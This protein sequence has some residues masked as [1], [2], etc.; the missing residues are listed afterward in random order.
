MVGAGTVVTKDVPPFAIVVGNPA[1]IIGY[2]QANKDHVTASSAVSRPA[3]KPVQDL[4]IGGAALYALPMVSDL[5]GN[6]SF[7]E[8]EQSLPFIPKRYFL[9]FDVPSKDVRGEHAHRECHQ[10]LVCVKGSCSVVV[11]DGQNRAEVLLNSPNLG[12]HV[13]PWVWATEYKYSQDAVL[14]VLAS[15]VYKAEDYIR[16]Y[17]VFL[18]E[19]KQ[20]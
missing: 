11:D 1:R 17:D 20:R 10:F 15:D 16:D 2:V 14:L 13:P 9:V 8:Y 19:V 6:L 3:D 18:K 4:G 7:A 12:L 5:R